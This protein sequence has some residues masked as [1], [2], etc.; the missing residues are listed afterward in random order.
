MLG[1]GVVLLDS[2]ELVAVV[3]LVVLVDVVL[4]SELLGSWVVSVTT[5]VLGVLDS[6]RAVVAASVCE[7][8]V[9]LLVD[10]EAVVEVVV[11]ASWVCCE[12]PG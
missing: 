8:D 4:V 2:V 11:E 6:L 3:V 9:L 10:V 12:P 1:G 5:S 7:E